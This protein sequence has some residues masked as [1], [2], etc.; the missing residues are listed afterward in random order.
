MQKHRTLRVRNNTSAV[1]VFAALVII[2]RAVGIDADVFEHLARTNRHAADR[3]FR[4]IAGHLG[5]FGNELVHSVEQRAAAGEAD[6]VFRNV[7]WQVREACARTERFLRISKYGSAEVL[8]ERLNHLMGAY[9]H[10]L[11]ADRK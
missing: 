9:H 3:I 10:E 1:E 11:A 6:A 7:R 8:P 2:Y 5:V 4:N